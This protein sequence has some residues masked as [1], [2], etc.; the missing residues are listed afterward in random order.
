MNPRERVLAIL[1]GEK[2]DRIPVDL[3]YTGEI[4]DDLKKHFHVNSDLELYKSMQLDKI[5]WVMAGY[6]FKSTDT[7][8]TVWGVPLKRITSGKAVYDEFGEPPLKNYN[9]DSLDEYPFW[10]KAENYDYD[11]ARQW[12]QQAYPNYVTIG[13]WISFF[14]VYCQMRGLQQGL[15]DL[16]LEPDLANSIL[17]RIEE[18]QTRMLE[19]FL[20]ALGDSID[21]VFVS[22]DM[23]TQENLLI[24]PDIWEKF[25]KARLA[26]WCDLIHSYGKKVFYHS[27]GAVEPL[28]SGLIDCGIDILNPIQRICKGMDTKLLKSKYG[29]KIVFHGAVENQSILPFGSPE[30]VAKETKYCLDTLASD[31]RG[32]IACSCHNIQAGT[33]VE[34]IIALAKAVCYYNRSTTKSLNSC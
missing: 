4:A 11:K 31:G 15:M 23:G 29:D 10:P 1:N 27:D 19:T 30:D 12:A 18:C 6:D 34:N 28:I 25:F 2:P 3:W 16:V 26:R 13:P 33:P 14:E 9:I 21:I 32:Y 22:D 7:N 8:R 20:K 17:D 5:V 24:S